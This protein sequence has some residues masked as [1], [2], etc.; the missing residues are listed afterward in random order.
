MISP[1]GARIDLA[2][3]VTN[4]VLAG[5]AIPH[6]HSGEIVENPAQS[7]YIG[8]DLRADAF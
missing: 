1:H 8:Y 5:Q 3:E 2:P 6:P 7:T 4:A